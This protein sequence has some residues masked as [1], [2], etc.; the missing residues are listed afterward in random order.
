M[1]N[2]GVLDT[3]IIPSNN[4]FFAL[5]LYPKLKKFGKFYASILDKKLKKIFEDSL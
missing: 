3:I 5:M 1:R 4:K 2:F